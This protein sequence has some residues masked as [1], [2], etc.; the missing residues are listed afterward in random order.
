MLLNVN[1]T[2]YR[3]DVVGYITSVRIRCVKI[4]NLYRIFAVGT[5]L[6]Y[7]EFKYDYIR[8]M[9]SHNSIS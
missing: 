7:S 5:V 6:L 9:F 2:V 1:T 4:I 3:L 8:K